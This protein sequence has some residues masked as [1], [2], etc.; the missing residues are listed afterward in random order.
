MLK[1]SFDTVFDKAVTRD[2]IAKF[3]DEV[4]VKLADTLR[5]ELAKN[6]PELAN[7]NKEFSFYKNL[8]T[9]M[10]ETLSRTTGQA[11]VGLLQAIK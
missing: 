6:N 10:Q 8:D 5:T 1:R 2:K 11:D 9:V 4:D 3:Q 7:L